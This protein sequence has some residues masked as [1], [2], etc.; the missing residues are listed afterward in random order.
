MLQTLLSIF[1]PP[2]D[3]ETRVLNTT[4]LPPNIHT[5]TSPNGIRILS[6]SK[7]TNP[8]VQSSLFVLK[9]HGTTHAASL[10]ATLL[11]DVIM[12]EIADVELWRNKNVLI[13]P[14]PSSTKRKKIRGFNPVEKICEGLPEELQKRMANT[15]LVQTRDVPAQKVL[16]RRRRLENKAGIFSVTSDI[17]GA[18]I[19]LIDD[20]VTTG[21]TLEEATRTLERAQ[22][23]VMPVACARS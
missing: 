21:A 16:S 7:Y 22:A 15:V 11:S 12:E 4:V 18:L 5:T 10:L 8:K 1:F 6:C 9:E 23:T 13:V 19:I 2:T 3:H 17:K 14:M 20:V